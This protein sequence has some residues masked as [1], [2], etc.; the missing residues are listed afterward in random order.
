MWLVIKAV[1]ADWGGFGE[2][3][4][5]MKGEP[6]VPVAEM[7]LANTPR[8]VFS[9]L[10]LQA[11]LFPGPRADVLGLVVLLL[12]HLLCACRRLRRKG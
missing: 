5:E 10:V 2:K 3:E 11:W 12:D 9:A 4:K 6:L 8:G 1:N 7:T